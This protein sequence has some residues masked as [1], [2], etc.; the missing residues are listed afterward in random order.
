[1]ANEPFE[2]NPEDLAEQEELALLSGSG[3]DS[4]S[5]G[6]ETEEGYEEKISD[7]AKKALLELID[8]YERAEE[9]Y[10][11]PYLREWKLLER[12]WEGHQHEVWSLIAEDWKNISEYD[13]E[14]DLDLEGFKPKT[15]NTYRG[16]G[17]SVIA[18]MSSGVPAT[19]FFPDDAD[20]QDDVSTAK[21]YSRAAELI[22]RRNKAPLLVIKILYILWN[23][24]VC[25][26]YSFARK[27][28]K[29]GNIS[30]PIEGP[31]Q[32]PVVNQFCSSCGAP[33]QGIPCP[34]CG[35]EDPP[36]VE[37]T[38][39]VTNGIIGQED[40]ERITED[41]NIYSPLYFRVPH[42]VTK[43]A[44][45]PYIGLDLE[46]SP[47][48][49]IAAFK[50]ETE[51]IREL[52]SPTKDTEKH[53]RWARAS[54]ENE[55]E[56]VT[57][58][59]RWVRS[60]ALEEI[61]DD[62]ARE[63]LLEIFPNGVYVALA[64]EN[65]IT[66]REENLDDHWTI[67][68]SPVSSHVF[69]RALGMSVK[70]IGDMTNEL[71]TMILDNIE[72]GTPITFVNKSLFNLRK[73]KESKTVPGMVYPVDVQPGSN[74]SNEIYESRPATLSDETKH[75]LN[76]LK[77]YGQFS[78][79][80]FPSIYGG[81][82]ESGSGTAREYVESRQQALQRLQITWKTVNEFW[83]DMMAKSVKDYLKNLSYDERFTKPHGKDSFMNVWIRKSEAQGKIGEVIAESSERF[84][85]NWIQK[86]D[87][88]I[89]MLRLGEPNI[90]AAMFHPEN[91][92]L[93]A[94]NLGFPE[95]YIPG[96]DDRSK[97][98]NEIIELLQGQPIP[99]MGPMGP[100]LMSSVPIDA[101]ID[102]HAIHMQTVKTF[103]I[104]DVGQT[105][106]KE[107]PFGFENCLAHYR[108]HDEQ[109]QMQMMQQAMAQAQNAETEDS[110]E[111]NVEAP[112]SV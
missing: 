76:G 110:G 107:N 111:P 73:F 28:P 50:N 29:L 4:A 105:L 66:C 71:L 27:D 95:F 84:P 62:T 59:Q 108:M 86:Q 98:L 89:E 43:Q 21:V 41:V 30:R 33:F 112:S 82:I 46:Q 75:F 23:Q 55:Y 8:S 5:E 6:A 25:A 88:M 80:A 12:Y 47:G 31:V 65:Y 83:T 93:V 15:V 35:S 61:K 58:R 109:M 17:E 68:T 74:L 54:D 2:G 67:Y 20:N 79:G 38:F 32:E 13:S 39:Q 11:D 99:M 101:E 81:S 14:D 104:S 96:D 24:G 100:T 94:Q 37:E 16:H 48:A 40:I 106:K 102:D 69:A 57:L 90:L 18:A 45:T 1:M 63:E 85:V 42:W 53:D 34:T 64:G 91:S 56:L 44:D 60:W 92:G 103:L 78:S 97:Q 77:E 70:D 51:D 7:H 87:L 49:I 26:S 3:Y 72:H 10:R 19:K 52:V 36:E 9:A 22:Q